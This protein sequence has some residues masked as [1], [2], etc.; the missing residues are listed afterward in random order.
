MKRKWDRGSPCLTPCVLLNKLINFPLMVM[1]NIAPSIHAR[2]HL[3]HF[4]EKENASNTLCKK[5]H[6]NLSYALG[7][8]NL[9]T[10]VS[11]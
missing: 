4:R 8:S 5:S 10:H 6:W 9:M 1:E 7:L 3:Y 2:I 11:I